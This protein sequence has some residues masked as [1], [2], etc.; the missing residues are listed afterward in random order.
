MEIGEK[1]FLEGKQASG[2]KNRTFQKI[3]R[4][5][6]DCPERPKYGPNGA[7]YGR[8]TAS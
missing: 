1:E 5:G 3:S 2:P 8:L 7:V 4:F 6:P